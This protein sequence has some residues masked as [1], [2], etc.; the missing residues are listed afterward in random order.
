M[1]GE[2]FVT[3]I[4]FSAT[5]LRK[6]RLSTLMQGFKHKYQIFETKYNHVFAALALI[7]LSL[8]HSMLFLR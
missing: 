6:Y 3:N 4:D 8:P 5:C 7:D 2:S 1:R